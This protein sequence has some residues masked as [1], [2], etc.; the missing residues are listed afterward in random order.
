MYNN[1]FLGLDL[2]FFMIIIAWYVLLAIASWKIFNKAGEAGWKSL[3]P[4]YNIYIQFKISWN[5]NM[6]WMAFLCYILGTVFSSEESSLYFVAVICSIIGLL[7]NATSS[8]KLSLAFGHG[9]PF[10]LG[11]FFINPIFLLILGF[12]NSRYEGPQ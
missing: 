8:Y 6:F 10:A 9:I 7:I 12:G 5:T 2:S 4:I 3:I 1:G 11:L